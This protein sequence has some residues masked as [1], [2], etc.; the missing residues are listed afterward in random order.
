MAIEC[1]Q[2]VYCLSA[3]ETTGV[4]RNGGVIAEIPLRA[5]FTINC[6]PALFGPKSLRCAL[7][8]LCWCQVRY[9]VH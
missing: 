6:P 9:E 3:V 2:F 7:K 1:A 4:P 5:G 8:S